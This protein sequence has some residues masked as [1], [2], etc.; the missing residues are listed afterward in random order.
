MSS[1]SRMKWPVIE[2]SRVLGVA[3]SRTW[4][5]ALVGGLEMVAARAY[6]IRFSAPNW[7]FDC[8]DQ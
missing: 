2:V 3:K 1:R 8:H 4:S 6:I 5:L 7:E